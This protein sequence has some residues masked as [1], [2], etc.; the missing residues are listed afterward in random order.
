[1]VPVIQP[2][3]NTVPT[4]S[5]TGRIKELDGLRGVAILLVVSFHY[6]NTQLVDNTNHISQV[7]AK[8]TSFGWVGV[9]LFFVLSGFLIGNILI[10]NKRS[11]NYFSTFYIRRI[12]RIIPNY[13][14]LL[15]ICGVMFNMDYFK[16]NYFFSD[17][18]N[19][20]LWSYFLMIHNFFM[21][22]YDSLGNRAL[23]I[24]WSIG[25]EEQFYLI[26]PFLV[27]YLKN[28]WLP[29]LL[30]VLVF[31]AIITRSMFH[32]WVP[33]YVLLPSR[34]DGLSLGFLVAY[35]YSGN[36]LF[37]HKIK[38]AKL[39]GI[40]LTAVVITSA[41]LLW[42]FHDLG[43]GKHTLF[44]V[45]F[46]ILL[47]F[48]L[49][50]NNSL[51]CRLLRNKLLGWIGVISYSLYLFHYAILGLAYHVAGKNGIGIHTYSDIG[52]SLLAFVISIGF[53]WLVYKLL[54]QPM[55]KIGKLRTY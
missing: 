22:H 17:P 29:I 31:G 11:P 9:D 38:L 6:V 45:A 2:I 13:F 50:F 52:I 12:V 42:R 26:F 33:Q 23:S 53:S 15:V 49:I 19:I 40:L 47:I 4:R 28:R 7:L 14:F 24:T 36:Y 48:S 10:T 54:E 44:A 25:I 37:I 5:N 3:S 32:T 21:A 8:I 16:G 27:Y 41:I 43:V 18:G 34:M 35:A 51:Y 46:S 1:M 30:T 39:L 55:V 20:P